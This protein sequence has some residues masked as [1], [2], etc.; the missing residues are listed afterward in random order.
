MRTINAEWIRARLDGGYGT[1]V[2]LADAIGIRRDAVSKI[3]SGTRQIKIS[4]LPAIIEYF[5][6][7][8]A[9]A[10][11]IPAEITRSTPAARLADRL[12]QMS[13]DEIEFLVVVAEGLIARRTLASRA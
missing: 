8:G 7:Q 3:L 2:G 5:R 10:A 1:R 9:D 11:D 4:E 6:A 12:A 13:A